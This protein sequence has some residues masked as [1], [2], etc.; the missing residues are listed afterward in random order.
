MIRARWKACA[1]GMCSMLAFAAACAPA[2]RPPLDGIGERYVRL[3][4]QLAQHQPDLVETWHG[5]SSWRP[6]PRVPV[7]TLQQELRSV[8]ASLQRESRRIADR[9]VDR[10]AYLL[11]QLASLDLASRR[12][13]GERLSFAEEVKL[14]FGLSLPKS[15]DEAL[16][17]AR[18]ALHDE[19]PGT[20]SLGA[21]HA[22]FRR[23]YIVPAPRM[24]A[25]WRASLA[26]C[27]AATS[28]HVAVP[29]DDQ[30]DLQLGVNS[31]WD[32]YV[33]YQ[34]SHRS[35]IEVSNRG[36]V[37]VSRVLHLACHEAYPG[38]HFQQMLIEDAAVN[39]A[40]AELRLI[41]AFGPHLLLGEGA[42]EAG[43]Q[44]AMPDDERARLYERV[45]FPLAGLD[46]ADIP[47]LVAVERLALALEDATV[48]IIGAYLD[49]SLSR[50]AA[51]AALAQEA[52]IIDP[53]ALLAFAERH[54]TRAITYPL[55]RR[56][57]S[58]HLAQSASGP[59]SALVDLFTERPL[60]LN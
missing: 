17:A 57:V 56:L 14:A 59:W 51:T 55:G 5:D 24:E 20:A 47:R 9:D 8:Q 48:A 29:Q 28:A 10:A 7:A 21:R 39:A 42:A 11:G 12:L 50:D 27:R 3:A 33:R 34:G 43:T 31:P 54:R 45:L 37:D 18:L 46:V 4:L 60:V 26:A 16:A 22:A 36:P 25:V 6:G 40:R 32:G 1:V 2:A 38:H 53:D 49:S 15:E 23:R 19:L 44:L 52:A 13:L 30:I 41:A 35:R 58:R